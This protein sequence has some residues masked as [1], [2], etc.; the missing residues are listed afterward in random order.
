MKKIVLSLALAMSF[1]L[2]QGQNDL[3]IDMTSPAAGTTLGPGLGFDFDVSITN[4][5]TQAVTSSDT[6]LYYPLLNGNL[7]VTTQNGQQVFIVFPITGV[8]MNTND[9]ETRSISFGGLSI[10][11]GSAM[12]VDFC[13]GVI[14]TGP[15]WSGVTES[16]T[17]NNTD[18]ENL[19]Y[20]PAGGNV[21][22][23]ENVIFTE[24]SLPVLDGS[25]SDG[26]VFH[27]NVYNMTSQEA[28]ISFVDLTGRT[29]YRE[30]FQANGSELHTEI[31]LDNLPQGVMLSVLEVDGR[32]IN[33]KKIVVK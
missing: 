21:G 18:C 16:D 22:L 17:T 32:Q 6:L 8:T 11:N 19:P 26:Y 20:D 5:G 28:V 30:V 3:S 25:Y 1:T 23:A 7:L 9:V 12:N 13:G 31:S 4:L 14:G 27:V 24:G 2:A 10:N 15:N 29:V 33:A